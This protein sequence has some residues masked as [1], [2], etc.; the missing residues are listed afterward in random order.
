MNKEILQIKLGLNPY[1]EKYIS[2]LKALPKEIKDEFKQHWEL[3]PEYALDKRTGIKWYRVTDEKQYTY[4]KAME[5]YGDSLPSKEEFETAEKHG[6]R[7]VLDDFKGSYWSA[8]LV[9]SNRGSA[10]YF[11]SGGGVVYFFNCNNAYSV[12]RVSRPSD[13]QPS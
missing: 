1:Q 12:R 2:K 5:K 6:I 4:D 3:T 9:S 7:V 10:W 11:L 13:S 8:S